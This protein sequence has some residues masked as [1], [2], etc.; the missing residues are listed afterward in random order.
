MIIQAS[1][2]GMLRRKQLRKIYVYDNFV[3]YLLHHSNDG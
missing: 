2:N 1:S 3:T